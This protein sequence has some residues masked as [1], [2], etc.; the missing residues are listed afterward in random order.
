[1]VS[2]NWLKMQG[3][4]YKGDNGAL[5]IFLFQL[6]PVLELFTRVLVLLVT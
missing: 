3:K 4:V 5:P 2:R 6:A 1:M